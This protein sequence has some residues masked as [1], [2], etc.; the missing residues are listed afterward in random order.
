MVGCEDGT[1]DRIIDFKWDPKA[2]QDSEL[3][4]L[5][6]ERPEAR[7]S[8]EGHHHLG[9]QN[10]IFSLSLSSEDN[11]RLVVGGCDGSV[12]VLDPITFAQHGFAQMPGEFAHVT[13]SATGDCIAV[14]F[15]TY[16]SRD[17]CRTLR[18]HDSYTLKPCQEV[19]LTG[20][21]SPI[22]KIAFAPD[23]AFLA[24]AS[25]TSVHLYDPHTLAELHSFIP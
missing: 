22:Q 19:L 3:R 15:S 16:I 17:F 4:E 20:L 14:T 12:C 1:I 21:T 8:H 2:V 23:S 25:C 5:I 7:F 10:G 24:V 9:N 18:L 13:F 6:F 11:A